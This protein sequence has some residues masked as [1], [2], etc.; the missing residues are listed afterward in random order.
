M[1]RGSCTYY[2]EN[3]STPLQ[4]QEKELCIVNQNVIHA[5]EIQEE[6]TIVSS[7]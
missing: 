5:I 1:Y 2:I 4:L 7:V 6:D 3:E